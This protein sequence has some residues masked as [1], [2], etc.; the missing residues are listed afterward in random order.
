[1]SS[2]ARSYIVVMIGCMKIWKETTWFHS[3]GR[4]GPKLCHKTPILLFCDAAV[5][6]WLPISSQ[7]AVKSRE[8]IAL[9]FVK[10]ID[11]TASPRTFW[12]FGGYFFSLPVHACWL[13]SRYFW[14]RARYFLTQAANS[15]CFL[16]IDFAPLVQISM[17]C[18]MIATKLKNILRGHPS[19]QGLAKQ[20]SSSIELM[21]M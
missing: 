20:Q 10:F 9:D 1:M 5:L 19:L 6:N 12:R 16:V 8:F 21:F 18:P 11:F 13:C 4:A 15:P 7:S 14:F 3:A 2:F 17:H